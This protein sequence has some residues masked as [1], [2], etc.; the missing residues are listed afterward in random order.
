MHIGGRKHVVTYE[1]A[2]SH[3]HMPLEKGHV[4]EAASVF[5]ILVKTPDRGPRAQIMLAR[6]QAAM[7]SFAG[8]REVLGTVF[9]GDQQIIADELQGAFVYYKLGM[10]AEALKCIAGLVRRHRA[11]PTICLILG[12]MFHADGDISRARQCWRLAI[13]RDRPNGGV[14]LAAKRQLLQLEKPARNGPD[15]S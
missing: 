13:E 8:S 2:F 5:S 7:A 12:D 10:R 15:D 9:H 14:A 3:G 11:L 4:E 1:Q 6:C